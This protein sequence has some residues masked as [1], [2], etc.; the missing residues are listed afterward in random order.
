MH[1]Y[2]QML[3][4]AFLGVTLL[5][6]PWV[7][8]DDEASVSYSEPENVPLSQEDLRDITTQVMAK[9]P[10]LSSSS[11]IKYA[12]ADRLGGSEDWATA[13]FPG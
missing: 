7:S 6:S 1:Y 9:Q 11:G 12:E 13:G 4:S 5:Y 2:I 3:L 8:A 10:L